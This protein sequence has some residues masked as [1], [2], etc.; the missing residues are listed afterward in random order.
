MIEWEHIL[1]TADFSPVGEIAVATA[2]TLPQQ[3]VSSAGGPPLA[4]LVPLVLAALAL[5][6]SKWPSVQNARESLLRAALVLGAIIVLVTEGLSLAEAVS[7]SNMKVAWIIL[8]GLASGAALVAHRRGRLVDGGGSLDHQVPPGLASP[9]LAAACAT[10]LGITL[11]IAIVAPPDSDDAMT[12]HL[13]R[14]LHW[15]QARSVDYYPSGIRR[16]NYQMPFAEFVLLQFQLLSGSDRWANLV[17]WS[18]F[19]LSGMTVS[20]ILA[21]LRQSAAVQ[22]AGAFVVFTTPMA[23]LQA[24]N[25]QNDLVVGLWLIAFTLYLWRTPSD[26]SR[27]S[28]LLCGLALGLALLTKGTAY[29][30]APAM[31]AAL[32]GGQ[33]LRGA[34]RRLQFGRLA[35]V[36]LI[37][38]S[39]NLG[40]WLRNQS[41]YG[42]PMCCGEEYFVERLTPGDAISNVLR[43]AAIHLALPKIH[44]AVTRVVDFL[45]PVPLDESAT[46]WGNESFRLIFSYDEGGAGN[47]LLL[48]LG[49]AASIVIAVEPR[50]R[51]GPAGIWV[52]VPLAGFLAF[53]LAIRWQPWASRLHTPVFL[54]VSV[55]VAL[56]LGTRRRLAE[57]TFVVL[58]A[59]SLFYQ[60]FNAARPIVPLIQPSILGRN[61]IDQYFIYAPYF[62]EPYQ[63]AAAY[64]RASG[65]TEVG[66]RFHEMDFEYPFWVALKDDPAGPPY[67]RHV[68]VSEVPGAAGRL[69]LTPPPL[70]VSSTEGERQRIDG[71]DYIR[72]RDFGPLSVLRRSDTIVPISQ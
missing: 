33:L 19:A 68:G 14:V 48:L 9:L 35:I 30:Y 67:V 72:V 57:A 24:S 7:A 16:Q 25:A 39:L 20:L 60:L 71:F 52:A 51:R 21:Q 44:G 56:V 3:G 18:A 11:F 23:I 63:Q 69:P 8:A 31:G 58:F 65:E 4:L 53:S 64:V 40:P 6:F 49:I 12:Y 17:Q 66:L 15:I 1:G 61:R 47:S 55:P 32:V 5:T 70:V 38:A 41:A 36:V 42:S 29:I 10:I 54:A 34:D 22:W 50:L 13:G 28:A 37:A 43:N 2:T 59:G 46:T 45:S 62:R 26:R 27:T